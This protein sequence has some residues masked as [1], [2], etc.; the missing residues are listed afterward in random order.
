MWSNEIKACKCCRK[1]CHR[2]WYVN[3][4]EDKSNSE[5][6]T[7]GDGWTHYVRGCEAVHVILNNT[8]IYTFKNVRYVPNMSKYHVY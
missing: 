3:F 7:L 6:I 8:L 4:I 5:F 2:K 1:R